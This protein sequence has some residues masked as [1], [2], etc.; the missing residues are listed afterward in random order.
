ML[1]YNVHSLI[2]LVDDVRRFGCLDSFSA[3]KFESL[4]GQLKKLVRKPNQPLPQIVKRIKEGSNF[5]LSKSTFAGKGS[6]TKLK[7]KHD[8]GPVPLSH[9]QGYSQFTSVHV[10]SLYFSIKN[11]DCCVKIGR[12]ICIIC[13]IISRDEHDIQ[14]VYKTFKTI[15]CFFCKAIAFVSIRNLQN[16]K[17]IRCK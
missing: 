5:T 2:H 6:T 9:N 4:L 10:G 7:N 17:F 11:P 8:F 13:N 14:I 3:F 1:V 15:S 12:K 16:F